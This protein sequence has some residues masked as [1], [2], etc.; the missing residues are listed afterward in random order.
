MRVTEVNTAQPKIYH[1]CVNH[2]KFNFFSFIMT[3]HSQCIHTPLDE[4]ISLVVSV[5]P[6]KFI[7]RTYRLSHPPANTVWQ[8]NDPYLLVEHGFFLQNDKD[9]IF[10]DLKDPSFYVY[11]SDKLNKVWVCCVNL[12]QSD[13]DNP[14]PIDV[15]FSWS[16]S[17]D[18]EQ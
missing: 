10:L 4:D 15:T 7:F 17:W 1:S 8:I 5:T 14:M 16:F 9:M 12:N 11:L 18:L 6:I 3:D 13:S 2:I